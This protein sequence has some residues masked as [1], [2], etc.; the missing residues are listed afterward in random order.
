MAVGSDKTSNCELRTPK[1]SD[2]SGQLR[3]YRIPTFLEVTVNGHP[4]DPR[5]DQIVGD[6][7]LPGR[8]LANWGLHLVDVNISIG[9]LIDIVRQQARAYGGGK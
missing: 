8:P 4:D 6:I 5:T 1:D 9:N 2:H 7:G 3:S